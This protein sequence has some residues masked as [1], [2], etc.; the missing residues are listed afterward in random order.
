M[1]ELTLPLVLAGTIMVSLTA[2]VLMGGA[3][4]GGGAWD[5]FALGPRRRAQRALIADAIGPIWEA[6]HVW[7]ILVVVLLFVCFPAVFARLSVTLHVPLSLMLVGIVFR[8]S[9]FTFRTYDSEQDEVQQRWSLLFSISS[10]ITPLLLGVSAGAVAAGRI[11]P[12]PM[13]SFVDAYIDSWLTP[14]PIAIGFL[15]L[16]LFAFLAAVYLTLET[17]E[18]ELR[19]DF[20]LR[21]LVAGVMVFITAFVAIM[22]AR[23]EAQL[24]WQGLTQSSWALEYQTAIGLAAVASFAALWT[25][26]FRIARLAAGL[27]A[28][29]ILWGWAL[30]QFPWMLPQTLT[31]ADAAAP[32]ATLR[33]VLGALVV[34]FVALVPSL[35]YLL[36]IFKGQARSEK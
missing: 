23:S 32:A 14:F 6:N 26:R 24:V 2:Y 20:R 36:R 30:V 9:A 27:Q 13:G 28:T 5:L 19:E 33:L 21:A 25:R 34:G 7:L 10:V 8:G 4:F 1:G 12:H 15:T 17:D 3:D 22:L 16:A 31:I 11:P 35:I 29:L 18:A